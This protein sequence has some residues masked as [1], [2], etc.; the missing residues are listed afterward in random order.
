MRSLLSLFVL[1]LA[2]SSCHF[3]GFRQVRGNGVSSTRQHSVGNFTQVEVAG[4]MDVVLAQ[5]PAAA[6]VVADENL[7]EYIIIE[8]RGNT[9]YVHVRKN[10]N[11]RPKAGMKVYV[12][13]PE[14][15][16]LQ[17]TGSGDVTGQGR[18]TGDNLQIELTG[19]GSVT[20]DLDM[21]KVRAEITGSGEARLSGATRE[22]ET[23]I[24]GSGSIAA[25]ELKSEETH[26]DIRGSGDAEVYASKLLE[27]DIA[28]SGD[29]SYKGAPNVN[30][31][32]HGS[33]NVHKAD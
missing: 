17:V 20:L 11:L 2:C 14:Y 32:V 15:R 25:Y 23:E 30:Q 8:Q 22:L 26:V 1:L 6:R 33:G 10:I 4:P 29:V 9:L 24:N 28:G 18:I 16:G 3:M 13:A 27:I 12:T 5:G 31:S 7:L 21:P 19:S